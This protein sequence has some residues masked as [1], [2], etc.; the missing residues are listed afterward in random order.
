MKKIALMILCGLLAVALATS[1]AWAKPGNGNGNGGDAGRGKG[2]TAVK[3]VSGVDA[4]GH[5]QQ[6]VKLE[7]KNDSQKG[8]AAIKEQKL[9]TYREMLKNYNQLM[10]EG[11]E[12]RI[13][14][15][16]AERHWAQKSIRNM[17]AIGLFSGYGDGT[18]KPDNPISQAETIALLMRLVPLENT[19]SGD[20][21]AGDGSGDG[22]VEES[23]S[24]TVEVGD[25][26][27]EDAGDAVE[28]NT[29][30]DT[31][32]AED[33][34]GVPGWAKQSVGRAAQLGILNMNRFHSQ[35]QATR[36]Q[37]AVWIAKTLGLEPVDVSDMPFADG[38][39][40]AREDAG[41]ILALYKEGLISGL[42][43]GKFN[44]NSAITRA[45]M[46]VLIE[47]ILTRQE[48][49]PGDLEDDNNAAGDVEEGAEDD[50][51]SSEETVAGEDSAESA[52][53]GS[54]V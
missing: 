6:Q 43:G 40:I 35:V 10:N 17:A 21:V 44:P 29:N 41:Y 37:A 22:T 42:P 11:K 48:E 24:E 16:D 39:L 31:E 34:A 49:Q 15:K 28:D 32:D 27:S 30:T 1:A 13:M 38:L 52:S 4:R 2:S 9:S 19:S 5:V 50:S 3:Q 12:T 14:F 36:A 26:G 46:A 25:T 45:E 23:S 53:G 54:D 33:L 7:L 51:V 47:R 18:F 20:S 8:S